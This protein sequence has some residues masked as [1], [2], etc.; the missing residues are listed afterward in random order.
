MFA[1]PQANSVCSEGRDV[2]TGQ[3]LK[4]TIAG[5]VLVTLI[6]ITKGAWSAAPLLT[7]AFA[8]LLLTQARQHKGERLL[9]VLNVLGLAIALWGSFAR[10][11]AALFVGLTMMVFM[12]LRALERHPI[13]LNRTMR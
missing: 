3:T 8:F 2:M 5:A 11:P 10:L 7:V 6:A 12:S 4:T 13:S 1:V 9:A